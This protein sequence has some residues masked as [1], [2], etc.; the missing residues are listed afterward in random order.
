M[1][2]PRLYTRLPSHYRIVLLYAIFAGAW[3][4]LSDY[5][6]SKIISNPEA[7]IKLGS[8]KGL[9]FVVITALLF[10]FEIKQTVKKQQQDEARYRTVADF[11][12]DWEYWLDPEKKFVYISPSCERITGYTPEEFMAEP[13]LLEKIIHPEDRDKV[14]EHFHNEASFKNYY[15]REYRI[16]TNAGKKRWIAHVCQGV[17]DSDGRY[18][19]VRASNRDVTE[20]KNAEE[21]ERLQH[22]KMFQADK[23]ITLGTLVSGVAHE[24]N[25]P[26]NFITL[27]TP[28]LREAWAGAKPVLEEYY[29]NKGDFRIGRFNYSVLRD[30]V[31]LLFDGVDEGA[32]RIKGIV[33]RLKDYARPDPAEMNQDVDINKEI[34]NAITLLKN[35]LEKNTKNFHVHYDRSIPKIKASSQKLEQ[36]IINLIQNAYESLSN[37][38]KAV[39]VTSFFDEKNNQIIVEVKDEGSGIHQDV[40]QRITDPF[41]TTKRITGGTGLGLAISARII[42][43]HA[44]QLQFISNFGKGTTA[45]VILPVNFKKTHIS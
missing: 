15:S 10:F 27:N 6:L 3:I 29:K 8:F 9:A 7:L 44:G 5:A 38:N 2:K 25:N 40:M 22:E 34:K 11:A 13:V 14:L 37:P 17:F 36:V 39:F 42:E 30:K 31:D 35:P 33:A 21:R 19:G 43:E 45:K 1:K 20:R 26:T 12:Y 24:I 4:L 16:I 41:F 18:L 23:M 28:L 32:A